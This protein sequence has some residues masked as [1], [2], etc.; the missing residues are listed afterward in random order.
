M[1]FQPDKSDVRHQGRGFNL[2]AGEF[3]IRQNGQTVFGDHG[4]AH[5]PA[6][7][8]QDGPRKVGNAHNVRLKAG[9]Q[10]RLGNYTLNFE[11]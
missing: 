8:H 11:N 7:P 1:V 9:K 10:E 4:N 2:P 5:T 6:R 3:Q